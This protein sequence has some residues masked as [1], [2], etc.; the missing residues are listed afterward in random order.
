MVDRTGFQELYL[1]MWKL[2]KPA[3]SKCESGGSVCCGLC[4]GLSH[5]M[6]TITLKSFGPGAVSA[7]CEV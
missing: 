2:T 3:E 7:E 5:T 4:R 1:F 6:Y